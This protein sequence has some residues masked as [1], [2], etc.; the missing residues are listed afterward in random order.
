MSLTLKRVCRST[1][2]SQVVIPKQFELIWTLWGRESCY[3]VTESDSSIPDSAADTQRMFL[4]I[5]S[6]SNRCSFQ[7]KE[8]FGIY[9][10]SISLS[11]YFT[12]SIG[13]DVH[14]V[15]NTESIIRVNGIDSIRWSQNGWVSSCLRAVLFG[16]FGWRIQRVCSSGLKAA[17]H[18]TENSERG[19]H[20]WSCWRTA[21]WPN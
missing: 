9:R 17:K 6:T 5:E 13:I 14:W 1:C 2:E 3:I 18:F 19:A 16:W 20:T 8:A 15:N 12:N 21:K 10:R 11:V 4:K 7:K